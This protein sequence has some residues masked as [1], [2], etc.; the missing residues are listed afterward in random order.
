MWYYL[1]LLTSGTVLEYSKHRARLIIHRW[2]GF[3]QA[4]RVPKINE[5]TLELSRIIVYIKN[6]KIF[7]WHKPEYHAPIWRKP[8]E[9]TMATLH[10]SP[11]RPYE[12][13][14][15]MVNRFETAI[16]KEGLIANAREATNLLVILAKA[17][18]SNSS[19]CSGIRAILEAGI[20][21]RLQGSMNDT[22]S[23][24]TEDN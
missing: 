20:A 23:E 12:D 4:I 5:K 22:P 18:A 14:E 8:E 2:H 6:K 15:A 17:E 16:I 21:N 9:A 13:R 7:F 1:V 11:Y 3:C 10:D 19:D 24:S